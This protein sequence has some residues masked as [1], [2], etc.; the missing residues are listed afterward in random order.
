MVVAPWTARNYATFGVPVFVSTNA[1]MTLLGGNNPAV[2]GDYRRDYSTADPR[3][4]IANFSVADQVNADQRARRLAFEWIRENPLDFLSLIPKKVWRLWA[5]DGE[6]EWGFQAGT[7]WYDRYYIAFRIVRAANQ[8]LY[9][10]IMVL[11]ATALLALRRLKPRSSIYFG[12]L[13]AGFVTLVSLI[14]S[15]Q[16]RYHFPVMPFLLMYSG[17]MLV[18]PLGILRKRMASP[19]REPPRPRSSTAT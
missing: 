2:V 17:W 16:S 7:P 5:P 11:S 19:E 8:A 6:A 3:F 1:G 10:V 9:V 15:G 12:Y 18:G 13:V 14:F 4:A